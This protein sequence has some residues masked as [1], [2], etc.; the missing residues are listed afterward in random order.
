MQ[1]GEY[2][3]SET[4]G[5]FFTAPMSAHLAFSRQKLATRLEAGIL[6]DPLRLG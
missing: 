5:H 4:L 6:E 1:G 2:A 3:R